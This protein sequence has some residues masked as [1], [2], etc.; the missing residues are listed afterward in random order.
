MK[1]KKDWFP[2]VLGVLCGIM[3]V[4]LL[5]AA[6]NYPAYVKAG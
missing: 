3:V 6:T 1:A 5:L 2:V 4:L